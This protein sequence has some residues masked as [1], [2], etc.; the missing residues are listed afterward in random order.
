LRGNNGGGNLEEGIWERKYRG[1][2]GEEIERK[3]GG[4]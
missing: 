3:Y 1:N 2:M 4:E